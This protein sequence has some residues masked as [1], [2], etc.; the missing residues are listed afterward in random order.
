M[1]FLLNISDNS[2]LFLITAYAAIGIIVVLIGLAFYAAFQ[3]VHDILHP[4]NDGQRIAN[5]AVRCQRAGLNVKIALTAARHEAEQLGYACG[6]E[7]FSYWY[8]TKFGKD[9]WEQAD[10]MR[11]SKVFKRKFFLS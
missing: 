4:S 8:K 11:F 5:A 1:H 3:A 2:F 6:K 7:F 9:I 10:E